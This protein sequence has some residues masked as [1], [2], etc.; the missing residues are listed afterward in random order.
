[1]VFTP[2]ASLFLTMS[3]SAWSCQISRFS[4]WSS[5]VRH[6]QMNL[7]RSHCARGL[8]TA[9]PFP[10]FNMRNWIAVLSVTIP[11]FPP[12]ASISLT[13]CPF[14]IPPTAG[15]QLIWAILFISIVIKQVLAPMFAEAAAASQPAWP[16]PITSTSYLSSIVFLQ[17]YRDITFLF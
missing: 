17:K 14:A 7:P 12:K 13:I 15:L 6:S 11:M 3:S 10:I 8:Q 16:P 1:M 4:V 2:T 9:G 5:V